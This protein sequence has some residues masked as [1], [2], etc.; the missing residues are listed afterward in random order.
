MVPGVPCRSCVLTDVSQQGGCGLL[1]F[2]ILALL[3]VFPFDMNGNRSGLCIASSP[4][5]CLSNGPGSPAPCVLCSRLHGCKMLPMPPACFALVSGIV[6]QAGRWIAGYQVFAD[7]RARNEQGSCCSTETAGRF[8]NAGPLILQDFF[9]E[10][11]LSSLLGNGR[12]WAIVGQSLSRR[13]LCEEES[14]LKEIPFLQKPH[15]PAVPVGHGEPINDAI[16]GVLPLLE[17]LCSAPPGL[18]DPPSQEARDRNGG[19][20]TTRSV[21]PSWCFQ[22]SPD[23]LSVLRGS[24]GLLKGVARDQ[25]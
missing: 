14:P 4:V 16:L 6:P 15:I 13:H 20:H 21:L 9:W 12:R 23:S 11:H 24:A 8:S 7:L 5:F 25:V 10:V 2:W 22:P 19:V 17:V 18:P 3:Q 1:E